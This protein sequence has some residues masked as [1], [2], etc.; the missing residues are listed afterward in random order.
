MLWYLPTFYGDIRLK[1]LGDM[2]TAVTWEK[3]T[4]TER[5]AMEELFKKARAKK[6]MQETALLAEGE[7][8]LKAPL[9]TVQK[10]L[11]KSLKPGREVIDVVTFKNGTVSEVRGT[12][13]PPA[14]AE[15]AATVAKPTL[16]CPEPRLARAELRAREVL[17]AFTT[18]EQQADFLE[19][20]AF[21]SIGAATGHRYMITSRHARDEL[22]TF[23]R[24][25][26]D[27]DERR[28][29]CVHDYSVPAAEEM[30]ALH[31][32]LQLPQYEPYLRHLE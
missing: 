30:L 29:F 32:M 8:K 9:I 16:G 21:V 2:E 24:Q 26:Y 20:N 18:P 6:W 13:A 28:P 23:R 11:A 3:L 25:L 14:E 31:L 12:E 22:A 17:F 19:R 4:A 5:V 27:L 10:L 7:L 1:R 15:K